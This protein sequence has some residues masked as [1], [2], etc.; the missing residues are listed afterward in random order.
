MDFFQANVNGD[1]NIG[2]YAT[3]TERF[4]ISGEELDWPVD[5]PVIIARHIDMP[6]SGIF[7]AANSEIIVSH[8]E[9]EREVEEKLVRFGS[10]I[11]INSKYN[12]VGNLVVMNDNACLISPLIRKWK[13]QFEDLG[14]E[15]EARDI[16][17]INLVGSVAKAT[18]TGIAVHPSVTEDELDFLEDFFGVRAGVATVSGS[19]FV[20]SGLVGNSRF[21]AMSDAA[22]GIEMARIGEIFGTE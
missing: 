19:L 22:T 15:C 12:T 21:M 20:G 17:G 10:I 3:A 4:I 5:I 6:F 1:P 8:S 11:K 7:F 9:L 2:L 18:N 16:G 14:M 13:R